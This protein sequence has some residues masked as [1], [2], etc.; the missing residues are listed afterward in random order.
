MRGR[1][2]RSGQLTVDVKTRIRL[3]FLTPGRWNEGLR[4]V[5]RKKKERKEKEKRNARKRDRKRVEKRASSSFTKFGRGERRRGTSVINQTTLLRIS[6]G[7]P[8]SLGSRGREGEDQKKRERE[9]DVSRFFPGVQ[10]GALRVCKD[11]SI[12]AHTK[13]CPNSANIAFSGAKFRVN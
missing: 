10:I 6:R 11:G 8:F 9:K 13:H 5:G 3:Q 12:K 2:N 1:G 4:F 7:C